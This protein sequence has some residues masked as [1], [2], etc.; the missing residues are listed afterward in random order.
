MVPSGSALP[1]WLARAA[2][3]AGHW[4]SQVS[5][6]PAQ[7]QGA[8]LPAS[9]A[10]ISRDFSASRIEQLSADP[11]ILVV[12]N[13]ISPAESGVIIAAAQQHGRPMM[14]GDVMAGDVSAQ[15]IDPSWIDQAPEWLG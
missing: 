10:S 13:I 5:L 9:G 11:L 2:R 1:A 7:R 8:L 4:A 15:A 12:H 3:R 14:G 6:V